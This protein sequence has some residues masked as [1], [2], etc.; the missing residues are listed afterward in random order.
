M[1]A[2]APLCAN[3]VEGTITARVGGSTAPNP[4]SHLLMKI[5]CHSEACQTRLPQRLRIHFYHHEQRT[6]Y[7]PDTA[8]RHDKYL[9]YLSKKGGLLWEKD[10]NVIMY[11]KSSLSRI[12]IKCAGF[13][14]GPTQNT[15]PHKRNN[16]VHRVMHNTKPQNSY[17]STFWKS[18]DSSHYLQGKKWATG[19][20]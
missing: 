12:L 16:R 11:R 19:H 3:H 15:T 8:L 9:S 5:Q 20:Q 10:G 13:L 1:N 7:Q 18:M 4:V 17:W 2:H 6:C 14:T